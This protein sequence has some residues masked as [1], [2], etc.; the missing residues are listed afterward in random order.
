M[1]NQNKENDINRDLFTIILITLT[2]A[3]LQRE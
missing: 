3:G 1:L 2:F